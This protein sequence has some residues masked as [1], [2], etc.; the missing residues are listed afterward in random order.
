VHGAAAAA[1]GNRKMRSLIESFA[2]RFYQLRNPTMRWL[3]LAM[4]KNIRQL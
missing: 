3:L 1:A 2:S 4:I